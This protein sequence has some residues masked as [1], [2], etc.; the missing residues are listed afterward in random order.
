MDTLLTRY[1]KTAAGGMLAATLAPLLFQSNAAAADTPRKHLNNDQKI[2]IALNRLEF[3]PRP[4][5][6]EAVRKMGLRAWID[7]QLAPEKL[8]DAA[9]DKKLAVLPSLK[10]SP[11]EMFDNFRNDRM[12]I[13]QR[14]Q[15]AGANGQPG[16][17]RPGQGQQPGRPPAGQ[18]VPNQAGPG[19]P[20]GAFGRPGLRPDG[21]MMDGPMNPQ[22]R[23]Q[24]MGMTPGQSSI[25]ALGELNDS[26]LLRACE[27]SRQL[28]EVLVDFWS[29]HFNVDVKKGQVRAF[30]PIEDRDVIRPHVLGKFRELLGA[31]A[32]SP[33]MLF[34]LDNALSTRDFNDPKSAPPMGQ[35]GGFGPGGGPGAFGRP[36]PGGFGGPGGGP[37][38]ALRRPGGFAGP[39]NGQPPGQGA[40][41][42]AGQ[43]GV[44]GGPLAYAQ[45]RPGTPG[46]NRGGLNE[47]YGRELM[48][49]HTLGVDGGYTEKDVREVAR[50]FTGWTIDRANGGFRFA[51]FMHDYGEKVVLGHKI[52]AGQGIL[53]GEMVLDIVASHPATAKYLSF[54]L[55]QRFVSDTPPQSLVDRAAKSFEK[56]GGDLREVVRTIVTSPEFL[57]PSVYRSKMKSPFE[58]AVSAARALGAT[59]EIPDPSIPMGRFRLIADG[60][61]SMGRGPMGQGARPGGPG[62]RMGAGIQRTSLVQEIALM[63][64]PLFSHEAPTGYPED[65][66]EWVSSGS[67]LARFNFAQNLTTDRIAAVTLA[68]PASPD[69][70]HARDHKAT[71]TT[72]S[73]AILGDDVSETTRAAIL[74]EM[75]A[76]A[77]T[78]RTV[79][80][81]LGSPEFQ[82]R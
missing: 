7:A 80:L 1:R 10:M 53:D 44:A 60:A 24:A 13:Q 76:G 70:A 69:L 50:C 48:E 72:L 64:Q 37:A 58:Y 2:L 8:D 52:P 46:A 14:L 25:A 5:D 34:Y 54:K 55:C 33:A 74:Q 28:Q 57:S 16:A 47:N 63:G 32:K 71:L 65:S 27:S 12:Q 9:V 78:R 49:L 77:D 22:M 21:E 67:L 20:P 17:G 36:G 61:I 43:G 23:M 29:N 40:G 15:A 56:T 68:P 6:L 66:R 30:K 51:P 73:R 38:G 62:G 11:Q 82:R 19:S 79:A 31:S 26:K 39:G 42:V 18:N 3:G 59:F 81:L 35:G 75:E 4:G 45:R 41:G